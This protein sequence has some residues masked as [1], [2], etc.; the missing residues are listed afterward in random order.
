MFCLV[1]ATFKEQ[2]GK[3]NLVELAN[4]LVLKMTIKVRDFPRKF[5]ENATMGN[6]ISNLWFLV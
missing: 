5:T 4:Y 6:Q 3:L 2:V 1:L